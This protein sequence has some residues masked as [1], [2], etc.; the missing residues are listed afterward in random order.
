MDDILEK[1]KQELIAL[2]KEKGI[3]TTALADLMKVHR[4][5]LSKIIS[6]DKVFTF[7][8]A[9]KWATALGKSI[10]IKIVEDE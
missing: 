1:T 6:G 10:D 2:T 9:Y 7:K 8:L 4:V 3:T 5:N